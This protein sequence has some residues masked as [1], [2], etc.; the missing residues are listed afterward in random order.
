[1]HKIGDDTV[2]ADGAGEF[3]STAPATI[4]TTA[5]HNSVQRELVGVV[6]GSGQTLSGANDLQVVQATGTHVNGVAVMRTLAVVSGRPLWRKYHTTAGDG[7]HLGFEGKTG[8][9]P[10]TYV[11][12]NGTIIVPTGG[13]GSAAWVAVYSGPVNVLWFGTNGL[14]AAVDAL[15]YGT[16][17]IPVNTTTTIGSGGFVGKSSVAILGED[18]YT[19]IIQLS[20][21]PTA[22]FMSWS[23]KTNWSVKNLTVDWNNKTAAG[24][25]SAMSATLCS[26]FDIENVRVINIDKFGIGLNGC[27][28]YR[29][30]KNYIYKATAVN[31]QN[32]AI[33]VSESSG[34]STDGTIELNECENTAIN[35]SCSRTKLIK[36]TI[37]NFKFGGGITSEQSST[38]HTLEID[39]NTIYGGTG[40]DVNATACP[41]IEN[42]APRSAIT[43]NTCYS[44]AG[45][46][47]DQGGQFCTTTGN[48]CFN[49][50]IVG[51]SGITGRYGTATYNGSYSTYSANICF[52]TAGASGTQSYGF[53]DHASISY[54]KVFANNFKQNKVDA[55]NVLSS[56]CTLD[57][58]SIDGSVT[59]DP[60]SL[61]DGQ[62]TTTDVTVAG[63]RVGDFVFVSFSNDVQSI[64]LSAFVNTS[65]N[66]K[67]RF[68]NETGGTI[69]LASGTLRVRV[70]KPLGAVDY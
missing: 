35:I 18:K 52:D 19:S 24:N 59:Y 41:G 17:F 60:P 44:N 3:K 20:A 31:T 4:L 10:G 55:Q 50:G 61:L 13:D 9:A 26:R 25:N 57:V 65:N 46:G 21:N 2:T 36:N 8:A 6:E 23:S 51:G 69:D 33:L 22:E 14:Q 63:A 32:Q 40:T 54:C 27:S 45:S 42:W 16:V 38:C 68:Q 47:I 5:W 30:Y 62:G 12:N 67:V 37:K 29:I 56:L 34:T 28:N 66:V 43:N 49:N 15:T 64:I 39:G 48:I 70:V 58:G 7:G 11:D 53:E 1:M